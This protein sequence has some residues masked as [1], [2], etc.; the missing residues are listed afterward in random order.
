MGLSLPSATRPCRRTWTSWCVLQWLCCL[1]SPAYCWGYSRGARKGSRL[2]LADHTC[3][4]QSISF[5]FYLMCLKC[6]CQATA[7]KTAVTLSV[8]QTAVMFLDVNANQGALRT[9]HPAVSPEWVASPGRWVPTKLVQ[10]PS[11][12]C[13]SRPPWSSAGRR[14]IWARIW[15]HM[16]RPCEVRVCS[17]R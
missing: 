7:W 11:P 3:I 6:R 14:G 16:S 2:S 9:E 1:Y 10:G 13:S 8:S 15:G 17:P 12:S 5:L 4:L